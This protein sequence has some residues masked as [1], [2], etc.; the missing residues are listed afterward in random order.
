MSR[1]K[2]KLLWLIKI[3]STTFPYKHFITHCST[4][5]TTKETSAVTTRGTTVQTMQQTT[6]KSTTAASTKELQ[7][8]T[9]VVSTTA[10]QGTR[11]PSITKHHTN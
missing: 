3:T 6:V 4:A 7:R 10:P 11:L 5:T 9:T 8:T 2:A 1:L